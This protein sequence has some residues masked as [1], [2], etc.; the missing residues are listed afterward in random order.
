MKQP[1]SYH[2]AMHHSPSVFVFLIIL[3]SIV[4]LVATAHGQAQA[5]IAC[6][7]RERDALLE[8]KNG[9]TDDPMGQL[10]FWQRGEDCCL[11]RGIRCSNMTGHV[12]KLQLWKPKYNDHGMYAG[13][14]MVGLISP[15]LLSLEHLQ[16]LDLSWNSLSGSDGHIPVFIGSFRNLRYLNL[17]SMPFSG[18]VPPQLGNL[19]KLQVLDLSGCHSLQM[20]SGSGIAWLRNLPLLQYLNLRLVNLSAVDDWPYVMN[21]L[22][23]L[24]VLSLSG[25]SLQRANQTLPQLGNLT[26]LESLDLSGN[27]LNH[28]I[29]S[30]WIWNLTSLTNLVLSGNRLYGQV[31]DALA[32]MT[33]LQ[34][35][36]FS[37]NRYSTLSQDLVYV[38]PSS[39][40]EGVTITGANL[41][42]LCSLEILD[43]EWGLSSGNITEL[44]ESLVKCPSSKLQELRLRDNNISGILPKSM[45][46]FSRL[47]YLDLSLNYLTGQ[48][49]SEIGML[50][51]LVYI[52]LSYNSL[53]RLP[54]EIGMLSNLE[55]L[56]L[57]FNSLDGFMTEKH[58]A[59]LASLKK[60]FLQ[61]NSLEIMVD[62]E[63]LPPFRLN[64][65]NFYSC[66]IVP[67]F[68][69][70]MKSQVDIIKLDIANTSIKDT[71]PDWFWTTVSKAI[72]LDMSN[73]QISGK[74]PTNMKFMSLERFYLDSNLITGEIPQLP[75]NLEIL[76]ISNNLLSGH[77]P[78]NLGA[79][80]L[81]V[82]NLYSNKISGHIPRYL[83][84]LG[85]L[86]GELPPCLEM[87]VGSL[88]FLRLS[89][90]SF[91]GNFPSFL[92][93]CTCI[94]FIDLS[95][96]KLSGTLP[97]WIGDLGNL[98]ILRLSHN[99]FSGDIPTSITLLSEL[100]HLDLSGNNISGAIPNNLSKIIAMTGKRYDLNYEIPAAMGANYTSPVATKG[101][102]RQYNERNVE[103]V[104][105]DL[106]SNFL[107]GRIPEDI[108][109]LRGLVNLNLSRN[110]LSG[111][112]PYGIGAMRSLASLDLSDNKLYGDIPPS[113]STL[114]FLSYLNLSYNNLTGSIPSGS[115]L[116]TIYNQH[117]DI[118]N[119]NSGLCGPPLQKNCS[120]NNVPK[121]G[122]MERT[123]QGFH[124]EPFFFG[125]VMGLIVG[126]WLV[127]CT[128]LFKKSWRVAYFRFFDKMYDKAYV[129]VVVGWAR[130]TR[131]TATI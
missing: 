59:R 99:I 12:I 93:N 30:C 128:L 116:E 34:V 26:R 67:M 33:S 21:T 16:H 102:E 46:M 63:W 115:Q 103:V 29:A 92:R 105:I 118:Y 37:F 49:P 36:Y 90:N 119:G 110:H 98:L 68:P 76:D 40:T 96:N 10:K 51:N 78:S 43:L 113:L 80:N 14:G 35:L 120:S 1:Q 94:H 2:L 53:S 15:S 24:T 11:W 65:A 111:K 112:I 22:P 87:G 4:F 23:F 73:N 18:M 6:I 91:S 81:V 66:R 127:F 20:Q 42:N 5:P 107:T 130:L 129:L 39:T 25:C 122:H 19:S 104:N 109:S 124:I 56:D 55:H 50:T 125:L 57:G 7:P 82:L 45:G 126:L 131:K 60:I 95:W 17:S 48:V 97:T 38:L 121:Q 64:Y 114:T 108:V 101:Q 54:S 85:T 88:E 71:L 62:P 69:I 89:N 44:I 79:P 28:P 117:P 84:E 13:N 52:D 41:R 72:Y 106:P 61:Y 8:F 32:N 74:L 83:C 123:G 9:I 70:W 31:P 58:F 77:L 3:T 27:Y 100:H 86:D 47:T 75:R